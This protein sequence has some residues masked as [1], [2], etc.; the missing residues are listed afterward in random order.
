MVKNKK[1]KIPPAK[2][3]VRFADIDVMGHVNNATYLSY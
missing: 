1:M 2:I 3:Q